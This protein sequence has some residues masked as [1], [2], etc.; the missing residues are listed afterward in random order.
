M[1]GFVYNFFY[2]YKTKDDLYLD[3]P[4]P[5]DKIR[6]K[7]YVIDKKNIGKSNNYDL[8]FDFWIERFLDENTL[9]NGDVLIFLYKVRCINKN[10][11]SENCYFCSKQA[12]FIYYNKELY[13]LTKDN[14]FNN[15]SNSKFY[16]PSNIFINN[17]ASSFYLDNLHLYPELYFNN[18]GY[19]QEIYKK[20]NDYKI[21]K[22]TKENTIWY[23]YT[24]GEISTCVRC[25]NK[26]LNYPD[27]DEE[28]DKNRVLYTI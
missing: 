6:N 18:E 17:F 7:S 27:K 25:I 8:V 20:Y 9:N 4:L 28:L 21:L 11:C 14:S 5:D 19:T 22:F 12:G 26:N 2:G 24:K 16:L 1:F 13:K 23:L 10:Y 3:I 15:Y